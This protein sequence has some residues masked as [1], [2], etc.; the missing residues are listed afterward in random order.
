MSSRFQQFVHCVENGIDCG[1]RN[2]YGV[3]RVWYAHPR[4]AP[5]EDRQFVVDYDDNGDPF[6]VQRVGQRRVIHYA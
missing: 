6:R 2:A 1:A 5:N 4:P 3:T